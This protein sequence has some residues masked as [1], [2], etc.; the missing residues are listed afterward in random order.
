MT[1]QTLG[2]FVKTSTGFSGRIKTL[3][4]DREMSISR[5]NQPSHVLADY[6]I[7]T[8]CSTLGYGWDENFD[9][10]ISRNS[11]VCIRLEFTEPVFDKSF[12]ARLV[13]DKDGFKLVWQIPSYEQSPIKLAKLDQKTLDKWN[14]LKRRN[15]EGAYAR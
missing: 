6:R 5:E 13:Q 15:R 7:H 1:L 14:A 2:S 9:E 3:H 10:T 8:D 12:I 11:E 4:I